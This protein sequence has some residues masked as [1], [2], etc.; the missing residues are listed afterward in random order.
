MIYQVLNLITL[1]AGFKKLILNAKDL[2]SFNSEFKK[3]ILIKA[4]RYVNNSDFQIRSKKVEYLLTK[5]SKSQNIS[6]KTN[7]TLISRIGEKI[8]IFKQ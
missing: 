7:K 4:M 6:L 8:V 3:N 1:E 2:F 5:I